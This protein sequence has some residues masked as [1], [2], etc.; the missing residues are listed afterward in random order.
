MWPWIEELRPH[1]LASTLI[2]LHLCIRQGSPRK[3]KGPISGTRGKE[4][5][6]SEEAFYENP[7]PDCLCRSESDDTTGHH[8]L[9][10]TWIRCCWWLHHSRS[11]DWRSIWRALVTLRTTMKLQVT[12]MAIQSRELKAECHESLRG[13]CVGVSLVKMV[14]SLREAITDRPFCLYYRNLR[15]IFSFLRK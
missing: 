10:S 3:R 2:V 7:L 13:C 4:R 8:H 11:T 9:V 6:R 14:A 15:F 5:F 12:D 1:L